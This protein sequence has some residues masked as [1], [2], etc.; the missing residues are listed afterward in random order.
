[1]VRA[2]LSYAG[3]RR[4]YGGGISS[5][6]ADKATGGAWESTLGRE[7]VAECPS[8]C[9]VT[10]QHPLLL[11]PTQ[12]LTRLVLSLFQMALSFSN[13][14]DASYL[15]RSLCVKRKDGGGKIMHA[16][17]NDT[18]ATDPHW[19]TQLCLRPMPSRLRGGRR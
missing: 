19:M 14:V 7:F 9:K 12:S 1:M 4:L 11:Q 16:D 6:M 2:D 17:T 10:T 3:R 18:I 13:P 5:K 8:D 15:A